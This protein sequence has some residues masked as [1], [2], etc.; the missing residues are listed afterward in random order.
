MHCC[1]GQ[2]IAKFLR[3]SGHLFIN[4]I[5]HNLVLWMFLFKEILHYIYVYMCVCVYVCIYIYIYSWFINIELTKKA[6]WPMPKG[7]ISYTC[8][9]P[10]KV[11]HSLPVHSTLDS[12]SA[13]CLGINLNSKI[14]NKKHKKYTTQLMSKRAPFLGWAETRRQNFTLFSLS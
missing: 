10:V 1:K 11:H 4:Q 12:S 3:V 8:V 7:N 13:L 5:I 2:Y 14:I 6:L 9:F